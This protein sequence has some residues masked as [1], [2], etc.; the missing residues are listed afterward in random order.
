MEYTIRDLKKWME[1]DDM[2]IKMMYDLRDDMARK[3]PNIQSINISIYGFL[4]T[5]KYWIISGNA[6]GYEKFWENNLKKVCENVSTKDLP[7]NFE[8]FE[9][10]KK[11]MEEDKKQV[12]EAADYIREL[13][14]I[15]N[16]PRRPIKEEK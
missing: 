2:S 14:I 8:Q 10:F 6:Y 1:L 3:W 7:D 11:D 12:Y 15:P 13:N 4:V 9:K 16:Q 5:G